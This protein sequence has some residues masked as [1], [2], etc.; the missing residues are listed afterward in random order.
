MMVIGPEHVGYT[1]SASP[2]EWEKTWK[3]NLNALSFWSQNKALTAGPLG[4][5]VEFQVSDKSFKK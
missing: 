1:N 4:A 5:I 3:V 2:N